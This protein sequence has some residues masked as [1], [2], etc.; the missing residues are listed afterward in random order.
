MKS[1][2]SRKMKSTRSGST[3]EIDESQAQDSKER[4]EDVDTV[5]ADAADDTEPSTSGR[6]GLNNTLQ[7]E[8]AEARTPF[9][10]PIPLSLAPSPSPFPAPS[11]PLRPSLH[12]RTLSSLISSPT[13][14]DYAPLC[15]R[16]GRGR[17]PR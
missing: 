11:F 12:R 1:F 2:L 14:P 6:H 5:D 7:A 13:S 4:L 16:A 15:G 17:R 10:F 9:L 3:V 8:G